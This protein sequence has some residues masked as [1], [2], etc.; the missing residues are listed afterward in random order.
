MSRVGASVM[1]MEMMG[2]GMRG[3]GGIVLTNG[4]NR[5]YDLA[6]LEFVQD[7]GLAGR[8]EPDHQDSH[9]L[10]T[11]QLIEQ[12]GDLKTHVC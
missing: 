11:P 6:Q 10:L 8:V 7:R 12:F 2:M 3:R 5:R 1:A 4:R 9:F